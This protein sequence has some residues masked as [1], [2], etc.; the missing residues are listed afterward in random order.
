MPTSR[1][2]G[3]PWP[4]DAV[5]SGQPVMCV[6]SRDGE[7]IWEEKAINYFQADVQI[8]A[9]DRGYVQFP[10]EVELPYA[11]TDLS[12]GAGIAEQSPK[13]RHGYHYALYADASSGRPV[14]GPLFNDQQTLTLS[15]S[16]PTQ[17]IEFNSKLYLISGP[18]M[19]VRGDDTASGWSAVTVPGAFTG[20]TIGKC[21]VFRGTNSA[22][23]L[24]VPIGASNVYY[25]MNAAET[26]TAHSSQQAEHFEVIG[27]ELWLA[28]TESN[29]RVIRKSTDGGATATWQGPNVVG[30]GAK[31]ITWLKAVADRLLV[32][33]EDGLFAP[34]QDATVVDEDLTPGLRPLAATNNG[35]GAV[36]FGNELIFPFAN[37]LYRYDP[38]DGEF[39]QFGPETLEQNGSEVKGPVQSVAAQEGLAIWAGMYNSSN[40]ASYLARF[41]GWRTDATANGPTRHFLPVWHFALH[42]WASKQV[43]LLHVTNVISGGPRL[44][45]VFTSGNVQW[46]VLSRTA[47]PID[48][49]NYR[50]D[51]ANT[52]EV[53]YP[54]FNGNFPFE[55]KLLKAIGIAGRNLSSGVRTVGGQYKA[56][57]DSSYTSVGTTG[58]DP[59]ERLEPSGSP[60]ANAFDF[61]ATLATTANTS[62]PVLTALVV[63]SALR[64]G[65]RAVKDITA[66]LDIRDRV[67]DHDGKPIRLSWQELRDAVQ[68]TM[69]AQGAISVI[70]PKGETITAMGVDFS[71]RMI[72][73]DKDGARTWHMVIRMIQT[74][75]T[76]TRGT[77]ARAS[78]YTWGQLGALLWSDVASI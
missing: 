9:E 25:T 4:Y 36:T 73:T 32:T 47:N 28:N 44:Y 55:P 76:S 67:I 13:S 68:A 61:K 69:E 39:E 7:P 17:I 70:T 18:L 59:G 66:I 57:V 15:S 34:S 21:V 53:Y 12:D 49:P 8:T 40:S 10:P 41:G 43:A 22:D 72:S 45:V 31:A 38:H 19:F 74:K 33:K 51:T 35:R 48:D 5:I 63:Y 77:W 27:D 60:A 71:Q 11:V 58:T 46:C 16:T 64:T 56:A 6:K 54:R 29:Q 75:T 30:D 42:K 3:P 2:Y 14:K 52:G 37:Q 62:S 23:L 50:F 26:F 78:A 20:K 65:T 24:F 1:S